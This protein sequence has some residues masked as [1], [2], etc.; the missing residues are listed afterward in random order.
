MIHV[1]APAQQGLLGQFAEGGSRRR[2]R[3]NWK[4]T[5]N[6]IERCPLREIAPS[7]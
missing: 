5:V 7:G 4:V 1:D 3:W 6:A 2:D